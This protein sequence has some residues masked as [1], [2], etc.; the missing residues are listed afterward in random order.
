MSKTHAYGVCAEFQYDNGS[1]DL[2]ETNTST[3]KCMI[4][5]V[6]LAAN[7]FVIHTNFYS[8]H[9]IL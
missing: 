5:R 9:M 7:F 6:S 2:A 3:Y 4:V 1:P 8:P